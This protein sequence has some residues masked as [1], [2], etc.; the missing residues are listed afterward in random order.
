MNQSHQS[1][2]YNL[3]Q[4]S[5]SGQSGFESFKGSDGRFYFHFNDISGK[6]LLFSQAY[7]REKDAEN[8]IQSV[9]RNAAD[10][11]RFQKRSDTEGSPFFILRAGNKQEIARSRAFSSVAESEKGQAYLVANLTLFAN[12]KRGIGNPISVRPTVVAEVVAPIKA[13][14]KTTIEGENTTSLAGENAD[15]KHKIVELETRVSSLL[16]AVMGEDSDIAPARQVFRIELY[17]SAKGGRLL[18]KIHHVL[19]GDVQPFSG[20]DSQAIEHFIASKLTFNDVLVP[21]VPEETPILATLKPNISIK[22]EVSAATI[23]ST[24]TSAPPTQT[25]DESVAHE[26][27]LLTVVNPNNPKDGIRANQAFDVSFCPKMTKNQPLSVGNMCQIQLYAYSFGTRERFLL[28]QKD[29]FVTKEPC[30]SVRIQ[31][32]ALPVGSHR[33][34]LVTHLYKEKTLGTRLNNWHG[35]ALV[36]VF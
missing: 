30:V 33:L 26:A 12:R 7:L 34:T 15:L 13:V 6:T 35:T 21:S 14:S 19:S 8:G 36:H 23:A 25:H 1:D 9:I 17:Q 32:N 27:T 10:E 4:A 31:A 5:P 2:D 11:K 24:D 3:A 18:G 22:K 20:L 16:T 28:L 29:I